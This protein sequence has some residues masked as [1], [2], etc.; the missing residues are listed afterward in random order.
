MG[1]FADQ[2]THK[3]KTSE[4]ERDEWMTSV[5]G[6]KHKWLLC[7]PDEVHVLPRISIPKVP[8]SMGSFLV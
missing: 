3:W 6:E 4:G 8:Y 1:H 5:I 7:V 2:V